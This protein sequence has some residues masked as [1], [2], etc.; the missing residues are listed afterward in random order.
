MFSIQMHIVDEVYCRQNRIRPHP[1]LA[2]TA[3]LK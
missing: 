2:K 3:V 1:Y